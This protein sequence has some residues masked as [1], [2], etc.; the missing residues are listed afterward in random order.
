MRVLPAV[1]LTV[2]ALLLGA[3]GSNSVSK[4]S[5]GIGPTDPTT[6]NGAGSSPPPSTFHPMF[7]V[8]QG[9]FPYPTDLYFVCSTPPCPAADG[10]LRLPDLGPL[11]PNRAAL[12]SIDGFSTTAPITVRFSTPIDAATL[13]PADVVLIRLT[14]DNATKGPYLPPAPGA[15]LPR[16]LAYGTDYRVYVSG[17]GPADALA[18]G[19]DG[20]GAV[21]VIEPV[22]PL[23]SSSGA[24]NIGYIVLLTNG[25]K[26]K[27]GSPA[28]PDNDYATV[29]AGALA[30]LASGAQ[31]PTC[32]SITTPELNGVCRLTFGH[33]AIAAQ[34]GL[35]PANVVVSFSFST[36]STS[37]TLNILW[38]TYQATPVPAGAIVAAPTSLT[39]QMVLGASFPGYADI[40][41][42]TVTVPYY[43]APAAN[44]HDPA[45]LTT[46]WVAAG[47]SPVPGIDPASR[48][49]TRFNPVPAVNSQQTIPM[50]VG[51]PNAASHCTEPQP[52]WP[53]VVL[54]HGFS[55]K[56]SDTLTL[57]D[58]YTG[59]CFVVVAIDLPLHG[60]VDPANPFF[61][62]QLFHGTPAAA[63][64][65]GERTFDLDVEN[66]STGAAGPDGV[67]DPSGD[68]FYN[69][70]GSPLT[71]RDDLRQATSD[72]LWLAHVLPTLSLG[73][74]KN[75]VSDVDGTQ[76]Q[77]TSLSLG[78]IVGIPTLAVV[79]PV[80]HASSSPFLTG[81]ASVSGSSFAYVARDSAGFGPRL[82]AQLKALS[83]G[84]AVPGATLYDNFFRDFENVVDTSDPANYAAA[85]VAFRPILMQQ[86]IGG[87][88]LPDSSLNLPDQ[89]VPNSSTVRL[90]AAANFVRETPGQTLL[91]AGT[92]AYVNFIYGQHASLI[93]PRGTTNTGPTNLA[94]FAE[95]Q[96]EAVA[97]SVAR[98]QAVT[99]G[100]ASAAVVQH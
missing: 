81:V 92:G 73:V 17:A 65:T 13:N 24:T 54:Q 2:A 89:G 79:N 33:L 27:S 46:H 59:H 32:A 90:I 85:A 87:G 9:I 63:L 53:V 91:P 100:A 76:L 28:V 39:T 52:G 69:S 80:T 4:G 42:G 48:N 64:M 14:L 55:S 70:V 84:A 45:P 97:F 41:A 22:R 98:G 31:T 61:H 38:A 78:G 16:A 62:N 51:V 99:V 1:T 34:G 66:N 36:V 75:G 93:D 95:M 74:N 37:D 44:P 57:F 86:V 43:L 40:W 26:D 25:I 60:I 6:G 58:A 18:E 94:A 10:T 11:S 67:I 83:G 96:T 21:L 19:V 35:N 15:Q 12:N 29:K 50:L 72:I 5:T 8:G 47:A 49:L 88:V 3:C 20:G 7:N 82:K 71:V 68:A 56:R 30:D 77:L 23:D